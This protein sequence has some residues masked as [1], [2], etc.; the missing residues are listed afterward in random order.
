MQ[1]LV[2]VNGNG[3]EINLTAGKFGITNWAGLSNTELNLQTQQV[4]YQ[5]GSVFI[6]AL[7]DNREISVTLAIN[8]EN[9]LYKR[10]QLKREAIS[11]LN[12]KLGEGYL[13][14]TNDFYSRRIKCVPQLP[15]FGNKNSND[16]GSLKA[17]LVW[18]ACGVYW[19][20]VEET[21]VE[22][23][24]GSQPVI[25]NKGDVP[26]QMKIDF[27]TSGVANPKITNVSQN[28]FIKYNGTL[29]ENLQI[30]TEV[31]KKYFT[32]EPI[33]FDNISSFGFEMRSV[34]YSENLGLFVAVGSSGTILT[35]SDGITW[36]TRPSGVSENLLSVTYSENLGLFV[37]VGISGRILTSSDGITWATRPSGVSS[38]LLS[39]TYSEN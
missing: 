28:K 3:E 16:A 26:V 2:F 4:P 35:S 23:G 17:S 24:I 36:A 1:K 29:N 38:T 9:D 5:D 33:T 14:Y 18:V 22:F 13:Y 12:P 32:A 25:D 27:F 6:D 31:G 19:E 39:V 21:V 8:D 11:A 37:A 34:T 20:D 15:I 7:L 30:S 10:Y